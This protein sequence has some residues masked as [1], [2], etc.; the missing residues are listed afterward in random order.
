MKQISHEILSD[1]WH[2]EAEI[3]DDRGVSGGPTEISDTFFESP[4]LG[5]Q[6]KK[7]IVWKYSIAKKLWK[8]LTIFPVSF[9]YFKSAFHGKSVWYQNKKYRFIPF[10][11]ILDYLESV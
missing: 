11:K 10:S 5:L 6:K 2:S 4:T 7:K 9:I 1:F 8:M 3:S